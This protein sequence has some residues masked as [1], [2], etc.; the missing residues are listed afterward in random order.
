MAEKFHS[1]L[2]ALLSSFSFCFNQEPLINDEIVVI[3]FLRLH[4]DSLPS[5]GPIKTMI[6]C[7]LTKQIKIVKKVGIFFG[8]YPWWSPVLIKSQ[9]NIIEAGH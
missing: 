4:F 1:V 7:W 6:I 8:K 2:L 3:I 9:V 5:R